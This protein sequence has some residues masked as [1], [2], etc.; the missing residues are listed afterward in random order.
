MK[1]NTIKKIVKIGLG[2]LGSIG[3]GKIASCAVMKMVDGERMGKFTK[4]C[5]AIAGGALGGALGEVVSHQIDKDLDIIKI[6]EDDPTNVK[7]TFNWEG[8][9]DGEEE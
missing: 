9:K 6:N 1:L 8:D 2:A 4:F 3:A 7:I 5:V